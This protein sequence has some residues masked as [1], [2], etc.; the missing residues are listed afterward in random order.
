[1]DSTPDGHRVG[2]DAN[3]DLARAA[4]VSL[5]ASMNRFPLL[6]AP[7]LRLEPVSVGHAEEMHAVLADPSI[8]EFLAPEGAP[9]LDWL[10]AAFERR[11]TGASPDGSELW[12]N[13]M[14]RRV[15]GRLIGYVQA[16]IEARDRCWIAY[17][18]N[19]EAR[20][21]GHATRAATAML[22]YLLATH[23]VTRF[24]AS[25]ETRNARSI[26]LLSRLGFEPAPI[27]LA[28]TVDIETTD[29]LY[30]RLHASA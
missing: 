19:A 4:A 28:G 14:V 27:E 22:D 11:S 7:S 21:H 1:M 10:K 16:T 29:R 24:L 26:A 13:W 15:D 20:G 23:G 3:G 30:Q 6:L 17:V 5:K 18:M 2:I 9:T 8:Y 12:F 25:T